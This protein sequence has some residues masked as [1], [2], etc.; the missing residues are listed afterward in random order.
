MIPPS[1]FGIRDTNGK[2]PDAIVSERDAIDA[3][4]CKLATKWAALEEER[5]GLRETLVS[6]VKFSNLQRI[7]K[8]DGDLFKL[9]QTELA[10]RRQA[11]AWLAGDYAAAVVNFQT[12]AQAKLEECQK[13]LLSQTLAAGFVETPEFAQSDL[14]QIIDR[15]PS[16]VAAKGYR[17]LVQDDAYRILNPQHPDSPIYINASRCAEI[18]AALEKAIAKVD[19]FAISIL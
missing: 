2:L 4:I 1:C 17:S 10:V 9:A 18:T 11:E 7:Q 12:E 3:Q 14:K 6:E 16:V 5:R 19:Q 8:I 13:L 15:H